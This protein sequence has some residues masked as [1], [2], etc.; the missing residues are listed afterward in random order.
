MKNRDLFWIIA[1]VSAWFAVR[2]LSPRI[3]GVILAA[4]VIA[5]LVMTGPQL[6]TLGKGT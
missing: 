3:A 5:A 2:S 4:L 1:G 6:A